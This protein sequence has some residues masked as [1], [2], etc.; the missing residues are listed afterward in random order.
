MKSFHFLAL[1]CL[2]AASFAAYSQDDG[3]LIGRSTSHTQ[4][5]TVI[6]HSNGFNSFNVETRGKIELTDDDR[7]IKSMSPDGYLEI[8]KTVFGS[9]RT[10]VITPQANGLKREY[11]EGRTSIP[12]EPEGR[13]WLAEIMPELIRSTTIGAESR[14]NRFYRQGGTNAVLREI[15]AMES[16]YVRYHYAKVLMNV[17]SITTK[18]YATIINSVADKMDSDHYL[19]EFLQSDMDKFLSTKESADAVF[20]AT[21]NMESDHYKTQ[22]IKEAL[23]TKAASPEA[24]KSILAASANIE[25]DHY[26]TEV[27]TS[28]MRQPNL[29]DPVVTEM[30]ATT[31]TIDSDHYRTVV[32]TKA[33]SYKGLSGTSYQKVLESVRHI[34]SDHYKT[35]VLKE[36]LENKLPTEQV[37]T[38][39]DLS[40][41]IDS[42][43]YLS[44]VF[45]EVLEG[46]DLN[47]EA[48]KRLIDRAAEVD[49]DHYASTILKAALELDNLNE[50]KTT[51][52][53]SAASRIDSDHYLT[54]VLVHAAPLVKRG[55][56]NL[57]DA[58]RNA[59]RQI[60]S[61]TY[62]GRALRALD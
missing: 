37:F 48:F 24:I 29:S 45:G 17:P 33:L 40:T 16:D 35:E 32:L 62:Y 3:F 19:T 56:S 28:L 52:I 13:K 51:S 53:L 38:L 43:H 60:G 15:A 44:I 4:N 20:A 39:V 8:T 12:Y 11:Y 14:V 41:S 46:Q 55:S 27:L 58:Y 7:D 1:A 25:S 34:E 47:D 57:K 2:I 49:S 59:A 42:D 36:L 50:A 6:R 22:I 21:R 26:K 23:R 30:I 10:L 5:K 18:D 31:R 54:E 61:E 9:R